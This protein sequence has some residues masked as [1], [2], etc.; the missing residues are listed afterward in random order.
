MVKGD[1]ST[2]FDAQKEGH[3]WYVI[4]GGKNY[5]VDI[6]PFDHKPCGEKK[7]NFKSVGLIHRANLVLKSNSRKWK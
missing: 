4:L 6:A 2:F 5:H 3:L 7:A 1:I